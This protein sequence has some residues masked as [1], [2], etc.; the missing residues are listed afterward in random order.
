V[1]ESQFSKLNFFLLGSIIQNVL[2]AVK[3]VFFINYIHFV[4]HWT[5]LLGVAAL[6][7]YPPTPS[8]SLC[9]YVL[10]ETELIVQQKW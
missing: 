4:A 5:A 7:A 1:K 2:S 9:Q 3:Q 8:V 6:L 10:Y